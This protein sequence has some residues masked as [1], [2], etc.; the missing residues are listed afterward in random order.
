MKRKSLLVVLLILTMVLYTGCSNKEEVKDDNKDVVEE[1][2]G[3]DFEG[4][5]MNVVTTS[6]KYQ[7]LFDAFGEEVNA[8]VEFLSMSSGEVIARIEAEGGEPMADLWFGGGID[9]FMAA[10]DS[11]LLSAYKPA[12]SDKIDARFVDED[13]YWISK[14]LTVVGFLVNEEMLK[15]K[16]LE[17]PTT[18]EELS[19]SKY[20]DE[21]IM[22]NPAISGT[23]YGAIKGILDMMGEEEGWEYLEKLNEN[24]P[25]YGKR[26]KDP[27]EKVVAGEF[28]IGIIPADKGSFD[29]AEKNNLT[30]VYPEDGIP[31]VPEGVAIFEGGQGEDIAKAFIDFMLRDE[32]QKKLSE[33]DGKDSAQMIKEGIEGYD[34]GLPKDKLIEQ[35]IKT[36]GSMREEILN[37]WEELTKGK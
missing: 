22:A 26:G 27:E 32:N 15:E 28:A 29:V 18:W 36:F 24:I 23:N 5:T 30:V 4:K 35:D 1:V 7:E 8:K 33:L 34:L 14:G 2:E 13:N 11:E 37:K 31:W 12:E 16:G 3:L 9:A 25:F 6:E 20:K 17:I 21:I 10:K 19:D